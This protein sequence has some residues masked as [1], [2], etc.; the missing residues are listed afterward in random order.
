VTVNDKYYANM[1]VRK[2]MAIVEQ[3]NATPAKPV[4]AQESQPEEALA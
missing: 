2:M 4:P 1:T 3:H